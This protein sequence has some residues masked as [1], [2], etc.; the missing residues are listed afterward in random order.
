[1]R[2]GNFVDVGEEA[3]THGVMGDKT[4]VWELVVASS[5]TGVSGEIL[6]WLIGAEVV[7]LLRTT[8]KHHLKWHLDLHDEIGIQ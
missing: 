7:L 8:K 3:E 1:M 6:R 2:A 4:W 5:G